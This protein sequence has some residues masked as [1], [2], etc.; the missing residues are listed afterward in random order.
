[1]QFQSYAQ[2]QQPITALH[3]ARTSAQDY[4]PSHPF[5]SPTSAHFSLPFSLVQVDSCCAPRQLFRV[6][7]VHLQYPSLY[8][9]PQTFLSEV[10]WVISKSKDFSFSHSDFELSGLCAILTLNYANKVVTLAQVGSHSKGSDIVLINHVTLR[11][12][13]PTKNKT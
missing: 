11:C 1:M 8:V 13:D 9:F 5:G 7:G 4:S 6:L 3:L 10:S 12:G 2:T